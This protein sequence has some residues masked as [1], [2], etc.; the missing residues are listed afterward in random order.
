VAVLA[1]GVV[2][3]PLFK[4]LGLGADLGCLLPR[5]AIGPFGLG[6]FTDAHAILHVADLGVIVFLFIIGLEMEPS[7]L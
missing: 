3:V 7:R 4:R 1:A 6:P 5:L 2:V